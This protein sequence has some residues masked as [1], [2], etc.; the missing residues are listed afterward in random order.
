MTY[1]STFSNNIG[2][3]DA[4]MVIAPSLCTDAGGFHCQ[5]HMCS[6][7]HGKDEHA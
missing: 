4:M 7:V 5:I 3:V 2:G 1:P 6:N